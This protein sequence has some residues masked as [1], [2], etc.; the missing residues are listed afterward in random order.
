VLVYDVVHDEFF[1]LCWNVAFRR[2][3]GLCHQNSAAEV[4]EKPLAVHQGKRYI[5][6]DILPNIDDFR[7]LP[8]T[9]ALWFSSGIVIS[10]EV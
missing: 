9:L 2:S 6:Q 4:L 8:I 1:H 5:E 3:K 7:H 10:L